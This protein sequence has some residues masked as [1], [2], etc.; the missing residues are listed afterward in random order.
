MKT[1]GLMP[2]SLLYVKPVCL[3]MYICVYIC[4]YTYY[5]GADAGILCVQIRVTEQ[6][7]LGVSNTSETVTFMEMS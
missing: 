7:S 5:I 3:H 1:N 6:G 2:H 4:T